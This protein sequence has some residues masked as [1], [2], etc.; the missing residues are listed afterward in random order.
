MGCLLALTGCNSDPDY[1]SLPVPDD[2]MQLAVSEPSLQLSRNKAD[3]VAATFTWNEAADRG[4]GTIVYLFRLYRTVDKEHT[5]TPIIEIEKGRRSVEMTTRE[6]NDIISSWGMLPGEKV[7]I[8]AEV[9]AKVVDSKVY[10]KPELSLC[11]F[12]AIGYNASTVYLII[13]EEG[14]A[15]R[16]IPVPESG[17]KDVFT[18][19]GVLP[20]CKFRI[21]DNNVT[22]WP[23]YMKGSEREGATEL[24]SAVS[25]EEGG[26]WFVSGQ[27][28][29]YNI[30]IDLNRMLY[31]AEVIPIYHCS[32]TITREGGEPNIVV[33]EDREVGSDW[34]YWEGRLEANTV[35]SFARSAGSPALGF[36]LDGSD[37]VSEV[38]GSAGSYKVSAA[39]FYVISILPGSERL[40]FKHLCWQGIC[41]PVG[42]VLDGIGDWD[43]GQAYQTE[44]NR[45]ERTD[46]K[47][48]PHKY[49]LTRKF[50]D[51]S[52][53]GFKIATEANWWG[54]F[55]P[56][57]RN[58]INPFTEGPA[59]GWTNVGQR[60]VGDWWAWEQ[61]WKWHPH[62][63][64]VAT[65][66]FDVCEMKL[67][68]VK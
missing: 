5:A 16:G 49:Y 22:G 4:D 59:D 1:Y 44:S 56:K 35:V 7:D 39:G 51:G 29:A 48:N 57:D 67:R 25:P 23:A 43:I 3:E 55:V 65:I 53:E 30:T 21:S 18:W 45:F 66:E 26:E 58:G 12:Q 68:M 41:A 9:I 36:D 64:G 40:I 6:L 61:D 33:L 46:L 32:M 27:E 20:P 47:Y 13:E 8:T 17:E 52:G 62:Y 10:R 54:E 50:K 14:A 15:L 37:R 24:V 31:T 38:E 42:D 19:K 2:R 63:S 11:D 34:F 60:S 28:S